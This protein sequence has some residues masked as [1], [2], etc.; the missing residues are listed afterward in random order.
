MSTIIA[1][2]MPD[3]EHALEAIASLRDAGFPEDRMTHFYVNP[4]GQHDI[5]PIGGDEA[6]S[7]GSRDSG[8]GALAGGGIGAVVGA[9]AGIAATPVAGPLGVP[10]GA[11][12]GAYTGSL[13]GAMRSTDT[14]SEADEVVEEHAEVHDGDVTERKAGIHVA[15]DLGSTVPEDEFEKVVRTLRT[16]GAIE[17]EQADGTIRNG[18]W[19]DFDPRK[20][21]SVLPR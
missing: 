10:I 20:V 18:S 16:H 2:L 1:A 9:V 12:I 11:G 21:V 6:A 4:D 15:V 13:M 8:K 19:E 14:D 3:Q 5:Y 17:L 7:P